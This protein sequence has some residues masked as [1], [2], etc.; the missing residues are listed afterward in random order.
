MRCGETVPQCETECIATPECL[1]FTYKASSQ[2]C[3]FRSELATSALS[4]L[5][6]DAA[7]TV[8]DRCDA[9]PGCHALACLVACA[10]SQLN[11]S[12]CPTLGQISLSS[13]LWCGSRVLPCVQMSGHVIHNSASTTAC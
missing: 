12:S 9:R 1:S 8:Y 2:C 6:A 3:Y 13:S 5:V 7:Y 10:R 4:S 11:R